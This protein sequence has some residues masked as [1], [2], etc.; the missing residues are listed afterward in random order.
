MPI[1]K[2]FAGFGVHLRFV[3]MMYTDLIKGEFVNHANILVLYCG[4]HQ[5]YYDNVAF[6]NVFSYDEMKLPFL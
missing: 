2:I 3:N 4:S 6:S 5:C 1:K